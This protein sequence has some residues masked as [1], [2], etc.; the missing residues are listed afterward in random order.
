MSIQSAAM[1]FLIR[2]SGIFNKPLSQIRETLERQRTKGDP[3]GIETKKHTI[4]SVAYEEFFYPQM[5][6][7]HALIYFHGGG[8]CLGV[9]QATRSFVA[10]IAQNSSIRAYLPD[11]R[12]APEN[13]FPAALEDAIAFYKGMLIRIGGAEKLIVAGDSSGCAL[14]LSAL[15]VLKESGIAMPKALVCITPVFDF[16]GR[17]D[18]LLT[19][20]IKDPF[21]LKDPLAIAKIYVGA[22]NPSSPMISPL[23]GD[24]KGLPPMLIH[25]GEYD[26]FLNDAIRLAQEAEQDGVEVRLKVFK[27]MWHVFHMQEALVPES[28][29]ALEEIRSFVSSFR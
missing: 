8:F 6:S 7:D 15:L 13:P 26:V 14:A 20:A 16:A 9:Y 22:N 3:K 25:A 28:S 23:Y 12:I 18:S 5:D 27:K 11:Y 1:R 19:S 2:S 21:H 10:Q 29:S 17:G 24:L 4:N